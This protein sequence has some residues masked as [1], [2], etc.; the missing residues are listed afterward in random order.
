MILVTGA[1]GQ[2]GRAVVEELLARGATVRAM[3][4][5]LRRDS[6]PDGRVE[7]VEGDFGQ[8]ATLDAALAGADRA[9]LLSPSAPD[10]V[11]LQGNFVDAA[12]RAGLRHLV[13]LSGAHALPDAPGLF[14]RWHGQIEQRIRESGVPY[15]FVQPVYF[16]QNIPTQ[17]R[18]AGGH[19]V[20]PLPPDRRVSLVAV[21][22]IAAVAAATL[23]E[24]GHEGKTYIVTGP[25]LVSPA[26]MAATIGRVR[27][28]AAPYR[29]VTPAWFVQ[30]LRQAGQP[31]W[32]AQGVAELFAYMDTD[33]TDVVASVA[34][35]EPS[36]FERFVRDHADLFVTDVPPGAVGGQA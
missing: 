34:R 6:V 12:R 5:D 25:A 35:R 2:V 36:S 13:K 28:V 21:G 31:E 4:R 26:E 22:D 32:L 8:P 19:F 18:S 33:V 24:P 14:P 23:G 1:T 16:M 9:F 27:G 30:T 20:A 10:Q 3:V 7:L 15:T 29:E 11:E 17:I